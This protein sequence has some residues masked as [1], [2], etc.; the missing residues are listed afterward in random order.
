PVPVFGVKLVAGVLEGFEFFPI[1]RDQIT[2]LME[3]NTCDSSEVF[4]AFGLSPTRFNLDSLAYLTATP[5]D[6]SIATR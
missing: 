2:M 3:G 6:E 1:T 5:R 4:A